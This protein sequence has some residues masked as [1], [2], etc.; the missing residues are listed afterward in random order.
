[1]AA[2]PNHLSEDEVPIDHAPL[3][4]GRRNSSFEVASGNRASRSLS[5]GS[6]YD[7]GLEICCTL[8]TVTGMWNLRST[9]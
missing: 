1:M 8:M 5:L 2:S 4:I 3:R 9:W 7:S 6:L